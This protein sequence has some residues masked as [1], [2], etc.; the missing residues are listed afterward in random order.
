MPIPKAWLFILLS[1]VILFVHRSQTLTW[2]KDTKYFPVSPL[3][4]DV[5]GT[6]GLDTRGD[7]GTWPILL[8]VKGPN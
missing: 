1:L 3:V 7:K 5:V 6:P 4:G 8:R 2:D